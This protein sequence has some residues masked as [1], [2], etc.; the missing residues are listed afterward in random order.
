MISAA[1][2]AAACLTP[3]HSGY[4][5]TYYDVCPWSPSGRCLACLR[6]PFEDRHPEPEAVAVLTVLDLVAGT[7]TEVA[8]TTAWGYQ[9]AAKQQ[10]GAGDGHLYLY[11]RRDGRPVG[12]R[13]ELPGGRLTTFDGPVWHVAPDERYALSP[14]LI[15]AN[16]TQ[17]GY[18]VS[19]APGEQ[20]QNTVVAA[21]DDGFYRVDLTTGAC[22]LWLPLAAMLPVL[23]DRDSLRD[24]VLYG[25]HVKISPT[26]EWVMLVVRALRPEG[27]YR[28]MLL[29]C[30]PDGEGLRVL[31]SSDRWLH[32]RKGGH[33][34][35]TSDGL[36]LVN[37]GTPAGL[38]FHLIDPATGLI[39]PLPIDVEGGGHPTVTPAGRHLVTDAYELE[40]DHQV[41]RVRW[42]D[43][44]RGQ[45]R[46]LWR[47][48]RPAYGA[49]PLTAS[50]RVDLHPV[51]NRD[52]S[53]LLVCAAPRGRRRLYVLAPDRP[54]GT[55][56]L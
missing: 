20:F 15:R 11:V 22:R 35:W 1:T 53:K 36:V 52:G 45:E 33:P 32:P 8:E 13:L 4:L 23:P 54:P 12:A 17:P 47:V 26:G 6:L 50:R 51:L 25:F 39:E 46:V 7:G 2:C 34:G 10:W 48:P 19:V 29:V 37:L 28:P 5:H 16:L 18:G 9:T 21:S 49:D 31:V 42:I 40:G 14:C 27:G 41:G 38:R 3:D 56:P 43:L 44:D 30:R 24:H 55:S